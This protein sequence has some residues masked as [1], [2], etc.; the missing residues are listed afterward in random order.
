[1]AGDRALLGRARGILF[2]SLLIGLCETAIFALLPVYGVKQGLSSELAVSLL[3]AYSLGAA[4]R[5]LAG[6][7]A[8]GLAARPSNSTVSA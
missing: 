5:E 7:M 6:T 1:V 3:L 4:F 8:Q 2:V